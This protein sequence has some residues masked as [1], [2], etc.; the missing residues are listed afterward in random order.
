MHACMHAY[1][2][3][4]FYQ[5]MQLHTS[6]SSTPKMYLNKKYRV[7]KKKTNHGVQVVPVKRHISPLKTKKN[8]E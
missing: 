7:P 5:V 3:V 2:L 1:I 6:A 4:R 8:N